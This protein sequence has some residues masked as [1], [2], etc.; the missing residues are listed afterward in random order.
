MEGNATIT[1]IIGSNSWLQQRCDWIAQV[2]EEGESPHEMIE[3]MRTTLNPPKF[4]AAKWTL[5]YVRMMDTT[6]TLSD[7]QRNEAK[8]TRPSYTMKSILCSVAHA[9]PSQPTLDPETAK[10]RFLILDTSS[11]CYLL[12]CLQENVKQT[13]ASPKSTFSKRWSKRPFQYSSAINVAVAEMVIEILSTLCSYQ[14]SVN[15]GPWDAKMTLLDPTCGSGTFLALAM[16]K[17]FH[18]EGYDC[19]PS[20]VAGTIRNLEYM[21]SIENVTDYAKVEVRDSSMRV[22]KQQ[23]GSVSCV[24]SNLPWGRNSVA[25]LEENEKILHLVR[26]QIPTGTP[27]AFITRQSHSAIENP[28]LLFARTGYE[29]LGQAHV[30]QR[31]F[32]LPTARK[33]KVK[34]TEIAKENP[35]DD[36]CIE[37]RSNQCIITIAT[38]SERQ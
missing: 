1:S 2:V 24:V 9:M 22:H 14:A 3:I 21:Y 37:E 30:P 38:A 32:L 27:C 18:V 20:A 34:P 10:D 16:E 29:V 4:S 5:D 7:G 12:K 13:S 31:D 23:S 25:Y 35:V 8:K 33:K 26:E 36:F 6:R 19:N 17:G 28:S 11:R 15:P